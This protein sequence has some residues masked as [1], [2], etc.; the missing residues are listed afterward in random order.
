MSEDLIVALLSILLMSGLLFMLKLIGVGIK[1]LFKGKK[2]EK[3]IAN[4]KYIVLKET[5]DEIWIGGNR[6]I[7]S[8]ILTII[9]EFKEKYKEIVFIKGDSEQDGEKYA[10]YKNETLIYCETGKI[11][12]V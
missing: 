11:V 7:Q 12:Q 3:V 1:Y 9:N 2:N 5:T 4:R 10:I 8:Q 6:L